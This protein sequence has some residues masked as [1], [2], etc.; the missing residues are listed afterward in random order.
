MSVRREPLA[1]AETARGATA[2]EPE[3][4]SRPPSAS[5]ETEKDPALPFSE[6]RFFTEALS[7]VTS[8]FAAGLTVV[9]DQ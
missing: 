6:E 2:A 4:S 8:I 3:A 7:A 5:A 1:E 9:S